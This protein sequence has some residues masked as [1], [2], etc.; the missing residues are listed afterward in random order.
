MN[1]FTI[2]PKS[3]VE[4]TTHPLQP[5]GWVMSIV[6]FALPALLLRLF[7][8]HVMAGMFAVLPQFDA[9]IFSFT[10]PLALL[11]VAALLMTQRE[12][13]P[14]TWHFLRE[15]FRFERLNG[16]AWRIT[17]VC[18]VVGFLGSGVLG[19]TAKYIASIP[20]FAPPAVLPQ[21]ID[22]RTA[23]SLSNPTFMGETTLGNWRI[24]GLYGV[25]LFFNIVGEETWWRGY[26]LPRQE[27]RFGARTWLVHGFLWTLFHSVFYPWQILGLA[28]MCF[29]LSYAAQKTRSIWPG[30]I[31]HSLSNG[32]A[33]LP[34]VLG[35]LGIKA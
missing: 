2:P 20:A 26:I 14:L 6:L 17:A 34:L 4:P 28:P 10:I 9:F 30:I 8:Y 25:M 1:A 19:L 12:A 5:L 16:R 22:P 35:V 7:M 33:M 32:L 24:I 18:F 31:I 13:H 3:A 15:R 27:A 23:P 11:L 21:V 29:A